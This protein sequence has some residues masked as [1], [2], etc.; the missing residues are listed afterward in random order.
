VREGAF[1]QP[2]GYSLFFPA[3]YYPSIQLSVPSS[4]VYTE[5]FEGWSLFHC[6]IRHALK[7]N[8]DIHDRRLYW[9]ADF[10][11]GHTIEMLKAGRDERLKFVAE[12]LVANEALPR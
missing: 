5:N 9:G 10:G 8:E 6:H 3:G 7:L 12:L 11:T 4:A 1:I 2:Q